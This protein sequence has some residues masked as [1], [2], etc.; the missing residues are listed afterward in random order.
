[1]AQNHTL[2]S[3]RPDNIASE[4]F[5]HF[6]NFLPQLEM[7]GQSKSMVKG[8]QQNTFLNDFHEGL[9]H[10]GSKYEPDPYFFT[11]YGGGDLSPHLPHH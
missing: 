10:Y 3:S 9:D 1:M 8:G 7:R 2:P 4:D 11:K 5:D 6:F